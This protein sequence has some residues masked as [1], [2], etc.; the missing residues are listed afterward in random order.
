M[1]VLLPLAGIFIGVII[2]L[3]KGTIEGCKQVAAQQQAATIEKAVRRG[4]IP[5]LPLEVPPDIA[6]KLQALEYSADVTRREI[7][8]LEAQSAGIYDLTEVIKNEK[9]IASAYKR[10]SADYEKIN[11]IKDKYGVI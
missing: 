3:I 11:K 1:I 9:K 6:D 4:K 2:G 10:L 7:G 5:P 8:T